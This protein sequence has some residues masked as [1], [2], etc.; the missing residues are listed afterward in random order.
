MIISKLPSHPDL[1]GQVLDVAIWKYL[2]ATDLTEIRN[3]KHV[4]ENKLTE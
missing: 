1:Q 2:L 4:Y 3:K